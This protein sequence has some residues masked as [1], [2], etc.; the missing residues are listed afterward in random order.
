MFVVSVSK[1]LIRDG[2]A[3]KLPIKGENSDALIVIK[4][5]KTKKKCI[6]ISVK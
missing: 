2:V 3:S 6:N 1:R 4:G 5:G